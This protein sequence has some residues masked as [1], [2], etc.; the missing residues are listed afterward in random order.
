MHFSTQVPFF[1][2][3]FYSVFTRV[4]VFIFIFFLYD[5]IYWLRAAVGDGR[6]S[7]NR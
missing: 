3:E 4:F 1:S 6:L 2:V 7:R 5:F